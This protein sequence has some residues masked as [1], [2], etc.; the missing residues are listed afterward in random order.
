MRCAL[1][2][3]PEEDFMAHYYLGRVTE[4]LS[5]QDPQLFKWEEA[6][7]YY[8]KAFSMRPYRA[9]PL[10]KIARHY[11]NENNHALSYVFARRACELAYP[12]QDRLPYDKYLYDFDRHEILSRAAWW[13][14]EWIVGEEA[15]KK[16]IEAC[17]NVPQY[18]KNLSYYWE[19]KHRPA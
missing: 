15:A 11:L 17:P 18:Y 3:F 13:I 1:N 8:L 12:T 16:T 2:S 9:D 10:I 14:G 19:R 7:K 6:L 5:E 4:T